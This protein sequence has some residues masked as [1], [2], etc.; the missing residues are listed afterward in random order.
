MFYT[1]INIYKWVAFQQAMFDYRMVFGKKEAFVDACRC[2][3]VLN[4]NISPKIQETS[5]FHN[6]CPSIWFHPIHFHPIHFH[7]FPYISIPY[8]QD[9][10]LLAI[11]IATTPPRRR[12]P[13]FGRHAAIGS[14]RPWDVG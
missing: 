3:T 5:H 10:P 9:T 1:Y 11:E 12:P 14:G 13:G 8:L 4:L 7:S 6:Q 2:N